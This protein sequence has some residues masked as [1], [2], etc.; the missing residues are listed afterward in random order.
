V[1][2]KSN[3]KGNLNMANERSDAVLEL[4]DV[5][6]VYEG[7][8]VA[9]SGVSLTVRRGEIVALLG[10]N[11]SG[12]STT[13]KAASGLLGAERGSVTAGSITY[14]SRPHRG[15]EARDLVQQGLVQ[16]LEGRHCFPHL[17]VVE[18]LVSGTLARGGSRRDV[19]D[20][21]ERVFARFPRLKTRRAS[22]AGYLSGGEQQMLAI[23]RALMAKPRVI[24]LDEPSMGLAPLSVAEI[25]DIVAE[26]NREDEVTIVLSE[27]NARAALRYAHSA[28]VL[29]NGRVVA[30]GSAEELR[31]R[32][33]VKEF[34]LGLG[35]AERRRSV[36]PPRPTAVA[37]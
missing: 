26:L 10:A 9:L 30:S 31:Q 16:V 22:R 11:G 8:I 35:S 4:K 34:Y 2:K 33:D 24:L 27:Q 36:P 25:F 17:T 19:A 32:D 20:G 7:I 23:G 3:R 15:V 29:E 18:N 37:P 28:Y 14:E 1:P 12:K 6:V 21:I 13:L 5:E